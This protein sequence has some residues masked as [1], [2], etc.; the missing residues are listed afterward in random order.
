[1][2]QNRGNAAT[3][4]YRDSKMSASCKYEYVIR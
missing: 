2:C 1:M 3:E 4:N